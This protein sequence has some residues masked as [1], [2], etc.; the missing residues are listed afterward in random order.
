[1][2]LKLRNRVFE[3]LQQIPYKRW[4]PSELA[5]ELFRLYPVECQEKKARSKAI[6]TDDALVSQ[7]AREIYGSRGRWED[8]Y[9]WL[10]SEGEN[11]RRLYWDGTLTAVSTGEQ[12]SPSVAAEKVAL[13]RI[14]F[15]P[16]GTGKT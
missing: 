10:Q 13:N 2:T 14:L 9:P 8:N 16:P 4:T 11:P 5:W 3:L 1:M 15:G 6:E 12:V 7:I